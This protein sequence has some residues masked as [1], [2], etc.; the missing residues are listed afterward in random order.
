MKILALL[1][2]TALVAA[3][4]AIGLLT[5]LSTGGDHSDWWFVLFIVLIGAIIV[6]TGIAVE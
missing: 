3:S 4:A 2:L 5:W 6:A 1:D